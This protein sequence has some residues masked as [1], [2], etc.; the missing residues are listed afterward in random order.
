MNNELTVFVTA[1]NNRNYETAHNLAVAQHEQSID[2]ESLFWDGICEMCCGYI[3]ISKADLETAEPLLVSS[4]GK[5]RNFGFKYGDFEITSALAGMR[6]GY[7]ELR[8]VAENKGTV[9]DVTMLPKLK[10]S[11]SQAV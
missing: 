9:F 4:M 11:S 8:R 7:D 5:L 3:A 6:R 2:K 1:F 10:L